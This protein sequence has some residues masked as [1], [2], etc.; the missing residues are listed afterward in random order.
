LGRIT[1]RLQLGQ[2]SQPR[3]DIRQLSFVLVQT[4]RPSLEV[5]DALSQAP[6]GQLEFM[7]CGIDGPLQVTLLLLDLSML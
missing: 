4:S 7:P 1:L 2:V 5:L 6:M 3:P